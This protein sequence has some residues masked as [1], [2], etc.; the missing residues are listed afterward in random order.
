MTSTKDGPVGPTEAGWTSAAN[1]DHLLAQTEAGRRPMP[2]D[3]W[4][5]SHDRL[6]L[7]RENLRVAFHGMDETIDWLLATLIARENGLLLGPPGVAKSQLATRIFE[8][9]GMA[10]AA[11]QPGFANGDTDV[12]ALRLDWAGWA[13]RG[14]HERQR[15]KYFHYLLSR[16]T[17]PDE[18]FGPIEIDLLR[19]GQLAR[20]NFGLL[21]GPGTYAAFLDEVFKASSNILNTL[22][23]LTQERRYFNW[24]GMVP[25]DLLFFIGASNELPEAASTPGREDFRQLHAFMDRFPVRL[26]I[27]APTGGVTP[28]SASPLA[29]A[30]ERARDREVAQF[31]TGSP[32]PRR[33]DDMPTINDLIC[34]GRA[35]MA[36]V[37]SRGHGEPRQGVFAASDLKRFDETFIELG[38]ALQAMQSPHA[39]EPNWSLSPRK[40]RS[41]Y[42]VALAHAVV[43]WKDAAKGHAPLG[44]RQLHVYR[45][46]WDAEPARDTLD[47]RV[48]HVAGSA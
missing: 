33:S 19:R 12:L 25:S 38:C 24:G 43:T 36:S 6:R 17:Q 31:T 9:L 32:F 14:E 47:Q 15:H 34:L 10:T 26:F 21:T 13:A 30:F 37:G 46:C 7:L 39:D 3:W 4:R 2:D 42:K 18:L 11:P 44:D 8:G 48:I 23:T 35:M 27:E 41:L 28:R 16:Y 45:W 1:T 40:L 5:K 20:V 29:K 22:L